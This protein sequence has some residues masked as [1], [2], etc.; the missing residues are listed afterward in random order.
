MT[1]FKRLSWASLTSVAML[2]T[3][4]SGAHAERWEGTEGADTYVGT[5]KRDVARSYAGN[6]TLEG[7]G[8]DDLLDGGP[9]RDTIDGGTGHD[10]IIGGD[11]DD[12]LIGGSAKDTIF[13]DAGNDVIQAR[14]G[15]VDTIGCGSGTDR[16]VVDWT[17]VVATTCEVVERPDITYDQLVAMF[18]NLVASRSR[19]EPGLPRLNAEMR[20]GNI[21][22]PARASAFLATIVNESWLRYDAVEAGVRGTYRGRGYIQ[23]TGSYNYSAA[24]RYFGQP[25][26]SNPSRVATLTWSA[27]VARWYWT[28]FR[29]INE[30]ADAMDM[31]RVSRKVGYRW[32][33]REDAKRCDHFR[34]SMKVLTGA[35]P[36]S[37]D[38]ICYR[39]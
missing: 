33:A 32:S 23:L 39:H 38:V 34:R 4:A 3:G 28:D 5:S 8:G 14:D 21:N 17:D 12:V 6:D 25:F 30:A 27:K 29:K 10:R 2:V 20:A 31:G 36:R 7:R 16:V 37:A 11:G 9:G 19:V 18:G 24:G 26:R 35:R 22:T 13:G 1:P 15:A